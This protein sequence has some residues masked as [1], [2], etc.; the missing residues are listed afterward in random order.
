M[1]RR[2]ALARFPLRWKIASFAAGLV[3]LC[4][5]ALSV[6]TVYLPWRQKLLAQQSA[7]RALAQALAPQI[8]RL[9]TGGVQWNAAALRHLVANSHA[10]AGG[11]GLDVVYALLLDQNGELN[12]ADST[13]NPALLH[14]ASPR[15]SALY[16][17]DRDR[18]LR[19]LGQGAVRAEIDPIR[20]KLA[21]PD[22][23]RELGQLVL[24]VSTASIDAEARASL[25]RGLYVLAATLGV[26][27]LGAAAI[28]GRITRPLSQLRRAMDHLGQG[29][30]EQELREPAQGRD[31]IGDLARTFNEMAV[32]LRER[33]RLK[34][35]LGRYVSGDVAERILA[36]R[37]DLSLRG[38]LRRVTVLFLDV[39]GFTQVSERLTPHE[40]LALLNEYFDRVVRCVQ[41]RGGTVNKFIGDAAMCIWGAP[42]ASETPERDAVTCALE[43]QEAARELSEERAKRGLTAINLGIG[44]NSGEAVAGNLG[45][46]EPLEY[47]V[48]GD[49]V[50]LAQRLESQ[51]RGGEV[52]VSQAVY[53]KV[54]GLVEAVSR[55]PVK[56][57][58]KALPVAL[59]EVQ[60]LKAPAATEAA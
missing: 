30:L 9:G 2:V 54:E 27:L 17:V 13:A 53:E 35:T 37:D 38:E 29:D 21:T 49:A 20:I 19:I 24:G 11:L 14:R 10:A 55:E 22:R 1:L 12:A 56:L 16:L 48:I 34:G 42:R 8:V 58:G 4:A 5:S 44:I 33:E 50:N 3:A 28:G 36:E 18:V 41:A 43:I 25:L 47:T 60:R 45:A 31:E 51:S 15:L 52:L 6:F 57:K 46:A 59:W 7:G 40:T 32:G 23:S 39:R 26:G